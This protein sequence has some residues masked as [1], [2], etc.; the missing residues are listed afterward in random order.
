MVA[1]LVVETLAHKL[2]DDFNNVQVQLIPLGKT[3]R[4]AAAIS[5]NSSLW[6]S[7]YTFTLSC[8]VSLAEYVHGKLLFSHLHLHSFHSYGETEVGEERIQ[9]ELREAYLGQ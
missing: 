3:M 9:I 7:K 8:D 4:S 5:T 1:N 6:L 2:V